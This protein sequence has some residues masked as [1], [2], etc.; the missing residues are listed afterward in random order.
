[1]ISLQVQ[2]QLESEGFTYVYKAYTDY[3]KTTDF[4]RL[5]DGRELVLYDC[6]NSVPNTLNDGEELTVVRQNVAPQ[7]PDQFNGIL[8][9]WDNPSAGPPQPQDLIVITTTT[10]LFIAALAVLSATIF[11][12]IIVLA[13]AWAAPCGTEVTYMEITECLTAITKPNCATAIYNKCVDA[14]G[15]GIPE[16]EFV[17]D[18][19]D[20][21]NEQGIGSW[22]PWLVGGLLVVAAIVIVPKLIPQRRAA[23]HRTHVPSAPKERKASYDFSSDYSYG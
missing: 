21:F 16:G 6:L 17:G 12:G 9:A 4:I 1:M 13:Q 10:I 18:P 22:M 20:P 7:M 3:Y 11:I 5:P 15:D 2:Q 23:S 19:D 14:D 8:Y